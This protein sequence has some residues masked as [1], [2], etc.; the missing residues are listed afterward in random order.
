MILKEPGGDR[1]EALLDA[2]LQGRSNEVAI[3]SAN[4]C[5]ILTRL[6]RSPVFLTPE[7]LAGILGGVE[8]LPLDRAGAERA[9]QLSL[10]APHLSLGDRVCLALASLRGATAWTTDKLWSK[11]KLGVRIELL[12]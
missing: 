12:R 10:T 4:W 2:I 1:V 9:A 7:E 11:V 3:S 8:L 5:E 6:Q